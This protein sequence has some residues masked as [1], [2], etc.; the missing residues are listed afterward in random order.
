MKERITGEARIAR[1]NLTEK[2]NL[3][4]IEEL[5]AGLSPKQEYGAIKTLLKR[6]KGLIWHNVNHFKLALSRQ[7]ALSV[8]DLYQEAS[9][10]FL[11]AAYL[12]RVEKGTRFGSF[13]TNR[14]VWRIKRV[15]SEGAQTIRFPPNVRPKLRVVVQEIDKLLQERVEVTDE[16]LAERLGISV[17]SARERRLQL[18][19]R[20]QPL[21][22]EC[23]G[24]LN[25]QEQDRRDANLEPF[26]KR[27]SED[28]PVG[29]DIVEGVDSS[30]D[31][32]PIKTL[33]KIVLSS[34][35]LT[36]KEKEILMLRAGLG[37]YPERALTLKE[38]GSEYKVSK[39]AI[40]R[41]ELKALAKARAILA[42]VA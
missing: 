31:D 25:P 38:L 40:A 37:I 10:S 24:R 17:K 35:E 28:D 5:Q 9:L 14:M 2:L 27:Y 32:V 19:I 11:E 34:D 23:D 8:D 41:T 6:N 15:L 22:L 4:N 7:A 39:Q 30:L 42:S 3:G 18:V 20:N 13:A 16:I 29:D 12:F 1:N 21:G 36:E 26:S 33:I